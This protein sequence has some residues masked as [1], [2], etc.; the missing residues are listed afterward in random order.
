MKRDQEEGYTWPC[1]MPVLASGGS[2]GHRRVKR[3]EEV[4]GER[5]E[6]SRHRCAAVAEERAREES[7]TRER[8]GE[9]ELG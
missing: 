3:R 4:E 6:E 7:E 2:R 1:R 8:T 5:G 9:N